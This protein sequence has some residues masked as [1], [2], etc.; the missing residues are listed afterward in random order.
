MYIYDF[1]GKN[2][3]IKDLIKKNPLFFVLYVT[4]QRKR[5]ILDKRKIDNFY[6]FWYNY[7]LVYI[8]TNK[9]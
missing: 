5:T 7:I 2:L 1:T 6:S 3:R 9:M 4:R 8:Y